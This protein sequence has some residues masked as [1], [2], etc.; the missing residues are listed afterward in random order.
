ME[1]K[2]GDIEDVSHWFAKR[3]GY[4]AALPNFHR[5]GLNILGGRQCILGKIRA[6]LL[7]CEKQGKKISLF[8]IDAD[9]LNFPLDEA[10][11]YSI[12]DQGYEIKVWKEGKMAYALV[13]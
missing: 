12:T 13:K 7:Y 8:I 4:T 5:Q 3:L 11:S 6:A 2:A 9:T 1:F 10:K